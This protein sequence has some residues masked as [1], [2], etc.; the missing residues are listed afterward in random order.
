MNED[1]CVKDDFSHIVSFQHSFCVNQIHLDL[2]QDDD[3]R[4]YQESAR[5]DLYR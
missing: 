4:Y 3:H 5:R 1:A 2:L